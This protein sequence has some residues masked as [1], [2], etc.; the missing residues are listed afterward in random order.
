M[1]NNTCIN[2]IRLLE[3]FDGS[4]SPDDT[5]KIDV[6]YLIAGDQTQPMQ[7]KSKIRTRRDENLEN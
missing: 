3:P 7:P 1:I 2:W 4:T 5:N 6:T